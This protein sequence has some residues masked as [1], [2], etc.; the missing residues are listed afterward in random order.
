MAARPRHDSG[1]CGRARR[2]DQQARLVEL[3]GRS[4]GQCGPSRQR[5]PG[6]DQGAVGVP[7]VPSRVGLNVT[8]G[9]P[10]LWE[11]GVGGFN[12]TDLDDAISECCGW[13]LQ[14]AHDINDNGWIV[15]EGLHEITPNIFQIRAF[16][17][18]PLGLCPEDVNRDG[19]VDVADLID[20]LV[21]FGLPGTEGQIYWEDVNADCVVNVL[22]LIDLLLKFG[23]VCPGSTA[24]PPQSLEE[25]LEEAGLTMYDW[26]DFMDIMEE[27]TQ[28]EKDNWHCWMTHYLSCHDPFGTCN[29]PPPNCPGS[30]PFGAHRH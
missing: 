8:R 25:A 16:L 18:V 1:D 2:V 24:A 29:P 22:D 30:D 12:V 17:L 23:T 27:G 19:V 28:Q 15:G 9:D 4:P 7:D 3:G 13:N 6:D 5:A 11:P 14:T 21:V 10:L 26:D 20:L